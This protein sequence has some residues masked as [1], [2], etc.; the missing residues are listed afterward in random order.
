[1]DA[2]L[3]ID[4]AVLL[5]YFIVIISIGL[6]MGRK[7][8]N[9]KDFALGGRRNSLVGHS[10]LANRRGD[11]CRHFFWHAGGRFHLSKLHL[12]AT[13]ARHHPGSHFGQLHFH[14]AVLRLQSLFDLRISHRTFRRADEK[15]RI[16]DIH[17]H[18]R[19]SVRCAA[20]C[21][22]DRARAGLR[23]DSRC[24]TRPERNA[25]H[26]YRRNHR[27][28]H[29][30]RHLHHARRHQS[31]HLDRFHS[32]LDHD[33]ECAELPLACSTSQSPAVGTRLLNAAAVSCLRF[34]HDWPESRQNVAGIK[35]KGCLP[36]NTQSLP[37]SSVRLL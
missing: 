36:S 4:T 18:A 31:G 11:E 14:Q 5:L 24:A 34:Y 29:I 19:S 22:G 21:S 26:L 17:V 20:V 13:R 6:Y 15:R 10:R 8:E 2:R 1:M 3:A 33:R 28:C 12:P 35:S 9:L 23:N 7:E 25:I 30:D 32:S 27:H 37:D 16:G